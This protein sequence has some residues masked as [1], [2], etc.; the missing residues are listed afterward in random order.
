MKYPK[1]A[2]AIENAQADQWAIAD[3]L[4]EEV[5]PPSPNQAHDGSGARFKEC[6]DELKAD[7][8]VGSHGEAWKPET[9]RHYRDVAAMFPHVKRL[10]S[11]AWSVHLIASQVEDGVALLALLHSCVDGARPKSL[12]PPAIAQFSYRG[13]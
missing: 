6:A 8:H 7:G 3:A 13:T 12:L 10:T 9:L 11:A 5:G 4:L 2:A 1:T